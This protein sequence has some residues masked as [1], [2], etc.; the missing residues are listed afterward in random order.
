MALIIGQCISYHTITK[1]DM[2]LNLKFTMS[3]NNNALLSFERQV[4][5]TRVAYLLFVL[6]LLSNIQRLRP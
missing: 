5:H 1:E 4:K 6:M 3:L 2:A